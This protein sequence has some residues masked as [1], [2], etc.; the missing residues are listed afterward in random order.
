VTFTRQQ[1]ISGRMTPAELL[2]A[3]I[4][5]TPAV[6]VTVRE[7]MG[8]T[9]REAGALMLV[10][11]SALAGTIGGGRLE[12][13]AIA[14]ARRMLADGRATA[15][16]SV[17]LGPETGQCCGGRVS[18]SFERLSPERAAALAG[19]LAA[20]I[21]ARP[22]VFVCG[23]GHVG[24][25]L[26]RA[27]APLPL[28]VSV[29]DGRAGELALLDGAGDVRAVLAPRRLDALAAAPPG[30]G[31][32]IMT[33]DHPLD[34]LLAAA[35]LERGDFRYL[36]LIGSATKKALFLR[37]FRDIGIPDAMIARVTCPVGGMAL[38]DKR[39]EVIAALAAAEIAVAM[40]SSPAVL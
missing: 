33:H 13:D 34:A 25:A 16:G 14:E 24:R 26:A 30:S 28:A 2:A 17:P 3:T 7:A 20:A 29:L 40:L 35:V 22:E 36:G 11:A 32:A 39:P 5:G 21:A 19:T 12:N 1:A 38:R 6:A 37:G 8:S 4:A 15:A 9:P 23:A 31:F 10:S 27:L 18:L